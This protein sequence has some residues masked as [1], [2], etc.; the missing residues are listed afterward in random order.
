MTTNRNGV[1][2]LLFTLSALAS[3]TAKSEPVDRAWSS[4]AAAGAA[5]NGVVHLDTIVVRPVG[6][7]SSRREE[8][9]WVRFEQA[10][11]DGR[12]RA[13]RHQVHGW[14]N[15]DGTR[16]ECYSP[17]FLN[18]CAESGGFSLLGAGFG[19]R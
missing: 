17:C 2:I 4:I 14:R 10:L 15:N 16:V 7:D 1:G 11:G 9:R 12:S 5:P 6:E 13:A 8:N 19:Y 18:C 3:S